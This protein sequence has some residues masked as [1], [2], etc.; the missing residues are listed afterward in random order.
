M[1]KCAA[2]FSNDMVLQRG[3]NISIWGTC[4]ENDVVKVSIPERCVSV[5]AENSGGKW[6]AVLPPQEACENCTV[7]VENGSETKTFYNVAIGEV[8][9]CGGQSNMELEIQNAK[10]GKDLLKE[11]TP[12]CRVRFYYTQKK[13]ML[14]EEFYRDEENTCWQTAS[15]QT[16]QAW[17]AVGLYFGLKLAKELG[18]TV[19][20][21]G[22][23]WGGTSASAWMSR[24]ALAEDKDTA[25][26]LE[27]YDKAVEGKTL[28][29]C[30][31]EYDEYSE[32]DAK[33]Y[34]DYSKLLEEE[35]N[36]GWDEAQE[37]IG[38]NLFPGPMG[39]KNPY[40]PCGL[41]ETM[42]MRICPYTIKGFTYYQGESDDH[43]PDT[44]YKLFSR[45]IRQWRED[46]QD[47]TLPFLMVQLPMFKYKHDPDY[48]HWAKIREAQYRVFQ[49]VKNT[50]IAVILDKGELDNIHPTDKKPVGERL[51]LQAEKLVYGMEADAFGPMYRTL[52]YKDG[53]VELL[54]DHAEKGF[55]IRGEICGF[56]IA[57]AD[58]KF[59]EAKAQVQGSSIFVSSE[60]VSEPKFVRYNYIN[61]GS[62]SVFGKNGIPLAPF[63]TSLQDE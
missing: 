26:Y 13:P 17:S 11:L 52:I 6:R 60:E 21:I 7:K 35:P 47:D 45:L 44:Y 32:Y 19:G 48:K 39:P 53:G 37:R 9:I 36:I 40:R 41:Y 46:W 30:I 43:R 24:E 51:C 38:K 55:D 50:G 4:G 16:S 42:L 61:Y 29:Q 56:E 2:V 12:S 5:K 31:K 20:L 1:L 33:W 15:E 22:C 59:Y 18:V 57:G 23:N 27:D 28:E 25:L 34:R 62:V 10:G 63:R 3:K 58:K 14:C 8:W 54:F 49:T